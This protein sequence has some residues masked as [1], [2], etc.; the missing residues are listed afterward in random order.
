MLT[1]STPNQSDLLLHKSSTALTITIVYNKIPLK[2][3]KKKAA[4]RK[5]INE[6]A[7]ICLETV[8]DYQK[9]LRTNKLT[10]YLVYEVT[11]T[12]YCFSRTWEA[13]APLLSINELQDFY[14]ASTAVRQWT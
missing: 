14:R 9:I 2:Y 6:A 11:S 12:L 1:I 8:K 3:T 13:Q 5:N 10:K 7:E 4:V